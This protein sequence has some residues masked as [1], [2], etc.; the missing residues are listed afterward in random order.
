VEQAFAQDITPGRI[1]LTDDEL[2]GLDAELYRHLAVSLNDLT[3][4]RDQLRQIFDE[5]RWLW[6]SRTSSP[7]S[8]ASS[9]QSLP[10]DDARRREADD[11]I[12][13]SWEQYRPM[14]EPSL[15]QAYFPEIT[16]EPQEPT[17][18]P[19]RETLPWPDVRQLE[20][21]ERLADA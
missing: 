12:V 3:L 21:D 9:T 20:A 13:D 5:A 2:I 6:G 17:T 18:V 10:W 15:L 16:D 8:P 7:I 14:D 19:W 4:P 11:L 1:G